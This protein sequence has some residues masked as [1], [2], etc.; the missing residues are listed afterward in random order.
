M[1]KLF[2]D[3]TDLGIG[4]GGGGVEL[5]LLQHLF[6]AGDGEGSLQGYQL[7]GLVEFLIFWAEEE[8]Y[9]KN[10]RFQSVVQARLEGTANIRNVAVFV[11][12]AQDTDGVND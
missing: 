5:A 3:L 7:Y 2:A 8:R 9:S 10:C 11:N 12:L 4:F 6:V 1:Y